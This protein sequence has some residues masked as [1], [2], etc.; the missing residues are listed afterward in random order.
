MSAVLGSKNDGNGGGGIDK[1]ESGGGPTSEQCI[2][3]FKVFRLFPR[4][5]KIIRLFHLFF[6][7]RTKKNVCQTRFAFLRPIS[8]FRVVYRFFIKLTCFA[9]Y[10]LAYTQSLLQ[11]KDSFTSLYLLCLKKH[12]LNYFNIKHN[13]FSQFRLLESD[14]FWKY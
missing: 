8:V 14:K 13:V 1:I 10:A 9:W 12:K 2:H 6:M 4:N 3:I 7:R 11:N 5:K